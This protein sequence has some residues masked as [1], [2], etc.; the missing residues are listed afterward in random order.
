MIVLLICG[1]VYGIGLIICSIIYRNLKDSKKALV[2]VILWPIVLLN[3][4]T[5]LIL[6]VAGQIVKT[7]R[8]KEFEKAFIK[9]VEN[10]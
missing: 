8:D 3:V 10:S 5:T 6:G 1:I 9:M 4:T 2:I 7:S